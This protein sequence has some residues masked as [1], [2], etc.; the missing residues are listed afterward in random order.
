MTPAEEAPQ[1]GL[2]NAAKL[3]KCQR[4]KKKKEKQ[5]G[6]CAARRPTLRQIRKKSHTQSLC[7]KACSVST[8]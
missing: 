1:E 3:S 2:L 8:H 5:S 4:Q 6:A 7:I